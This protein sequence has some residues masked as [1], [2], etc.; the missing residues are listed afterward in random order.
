MR[1]LLL[2]AATAAALAPGAALA[3]TGYFA[4]GYGVKAKAMG[5]VGIALPQ[6]ALAPATNPAGIAWVGNRIDLGA[7]LFMPDRGASITGSGAPGANGTYDGNDTKSFLIPEFGYARVINPNLTF[8]VAVYGNGGM[9]TDYSTNPFTAYGG[10]GP[11]GVDLM[12]LFVAPTVA[13]KAGNHALGVSLNLAYQRFKAEGI[14][15]FMG[16]SASPGNV[17]NRGYDDS[18][19]FGVRVGWTGQISPTVTLG[20]T[21]QSK[22]KMSEFDKYSG[23]FANQGDFDIPENYG[24]GI[25]LKATP[26]LTIAADVQQIN[27]SDIPAVGNRVDCLFMGACQLGSTN[28]PGFGW[29]DVTVYKI[30]FAYLMRPG[31]TLRGGYVT[32]D[33]PIP[34]SQT[35]F[36]I[37][38]PGVVED[39]LTL[40][41]TLEMSK[42]SELT[43]MYM[44]AFEKKV[45]GSGSIPAV[46]FGGGEA[47]LRMSQD[48]I[49]LAYGWRY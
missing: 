8:G 22:T 16:S 40:G 19:G 7:D 23:L 17:S 13:W 15:G 43:F 21:Y 49:G 11:A 32:L 4:H 42:T 41:L 36:N 37:L 30:G 2:A 46:P 14:Q 31:T 47:N 26:T 6:D 25:A 33:Q 35:F 29:Q 39:H 18:T 9:N 3:T 44:H 34:A 48:S 10:S 20:A 5:G 38:A 27:Y 45:N 28:G 1:K 24:V 12:Q